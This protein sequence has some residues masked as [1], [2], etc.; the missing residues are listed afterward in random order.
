MAGAATPRRSPLALV[1]G[2]LVALSLV[3]GLCALGVWQLHRLQWKRELIAMVDS[4]IHAAPIPIPA[5][6]DWGKVSESRDAYRKVRIEGHY[7]HGR[8]TLVQAVTTRG[9]GYWVLTPLRTDGGFTVLINRGFV[10]PEKRAPAARA[11]GSP[12]GNT[13]ITGLLR[14][15]EPGGGFLR[16]N[17]PAAN[18]WYSRDVAAIAGA[19]KL[20]PVAPFF[21]DADATPNPG[22]FPIGG[23]TVISFRNTHLAYA[24]TWFILAA[25][26]AVAALYSGRRELQARKAED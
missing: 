2:A 15:T 11:A 17:D 16:A 1:A 19:R 24:I 21:I 5:P 3:A 23:L 25:M 14:M 6:A 4:R 22:G 13:T 7:L 20:G 18:R 12:P 9:G 26:T 10:P 8:E